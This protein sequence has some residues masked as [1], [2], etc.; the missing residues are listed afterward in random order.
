M[1]EVA[2]RRGDERG[3]ASDLAPVA[4][5][6]VRPVHGA[7]NPDAERAKRREVHRRPEEV[8]PDH[9]EPCAAGRVEALDARG[10]I[11][12]VGGVVTEVADAPHLVVV[13]EGGTS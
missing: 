6:E 4:A 8:L 2:R 3:G 13:L 5:Q 10:E 1:A 11:G 12:T 7:P 9:P